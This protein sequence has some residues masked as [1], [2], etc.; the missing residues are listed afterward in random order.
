MSKT[1][2][3]LTALVAGYAWELYAD[4]QVAIVSG[5][6]FALATGAARR[7]ELAKTGKLVRFAQVAVAAAALAGVL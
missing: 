5:P 6:P 2:I 1:N 7:A 3:L 4:Q